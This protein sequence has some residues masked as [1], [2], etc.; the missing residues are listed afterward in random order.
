MILLGMCV[1]AII[2]GVVI[3]VASPVAA[4]TGPSAKAMIQVIG[5]GSTAAVMTEKKNYHVTN[6]AQLA[7]VWRLAYGPGSPGIPDVDFAT[8]NVIAVF[9]GQKSSGG[10]DVDVTE[11][12]DQG[13]TRTIT[14]V[15][16]APG[17]GCITTDALTSPFQLVVVP[18]S[19]DK[20]SR[21]D[22]D[23]TVACD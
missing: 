13:G 1:I 17:P 22:T 7:D 10:Y 21:V 11:V 9:D 6:Y 18:K 16:T 2:V 19:D 4:P 8:E 5:E 23:V 20:I 15:H 3:F 14:I 12:V